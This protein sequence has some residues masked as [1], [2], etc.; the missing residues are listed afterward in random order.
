MMIR[1][2]LFT[3]ALLGL[4]A[5]PS[6]ALP[7]LPENLDPARV[8]EWTLVR[9]A[10]PGLDWS[11]ANSATTVAWTPGSLWRVEL[12]D[13]STR[14]LTEGGARETEAEGQLLL[15]RESRWLEV[16]PTGAIRLV[17]EELRLR[18]LDGVK[19]GLGRAEDALVGQADGDRELL[20]ADHSATVELARAGGF[21]RPV[22]LGQP[23]VFRD[24][25]MVSLSLQPVI[26]HEGRL[27]AVE[28]LRLRLDYG[29]VESSASRPLAGLAEEP[30][31]AGNELGATHAWSSNWERVY[32]ALVPNHGQFYNQVDD[33]VFPVYVIVGSPNY[34]N[35]VNPGMEEFIKWKREKG[36]DVRIVTF[37]QMPGGAATISFDNLRAWTRTMWE[38]MR[39]EFLLLIG[40]V[41]GPAACP[42]SVVQAHTGDWDV[43]DHFY[44]LQEGTDFFPELFVGRYSVDSASQ[45]YVMAQKPVFHE[46]MPTLS[47]GGWLTRGLVVSCN[48]ADSGTPPISPNL[49]SRWV[50]DKLRANG[51]TITA[52][53]S[54]FYPPLTNG[55]T[56]IINAL[57]QG[58]GIV[59]YRGWANSNGWIYPAFDRS[60][61]DLL[62]N[63]LRM[64]VVGSFVCQTGA[65]GQGSGDVIVEDPCFGEKFV[66]LGGPGA[67]K[68]AV[69]FVG[70]S[71]LHTRTQY[72]NPVCSGFFTAIFDLNMTGIG[73]ALLN[74]KMEL[75]NGYPLERDDPYSSYFYFHIYNVLGDPDLNIWRGEPLP[76]VLTAPDQL[77][78][79]QSVLE[80][81]VRDQAGDPV[82]GAVVTLIAGADGSQ[83][84][85]RGVT[86]NGQVLLAVDPAQLPVGLT[87]A[88]TANHIDHLP[89]QH[90]LPVTA[91]AVALELTGLQIVEETA[92]G[93][94][95][96]GEELEVRLTLRASGTSAVPEGTAVLRDPA[97]WEIL[98]DWFTIETG[99]VATPAIPAGASTVTEEA[100][101]IRLAADAPNHGLLHLVADLAAGPYQGVVDGRLTLSNLALGL[102]SAAWRSGEAQ[103]LSDR[104]DTLDLVL[105]NIGAFDLG[106]AQLT[107]GSLDPRIEVEE[108]GAWLPT[109]AQGATASASFVLEGG[110]GLFTGQ[111]LHVLLQVEAEGRSAAL[112]VPLPVGGILPEDP[113][114]PDDHGYYAIESEDYDVSTHPTFDWVELDPFYGGSGATRLL[115][116]DDAVTTI[117]LPFPLTH[118]GRTG[119]RLSICSNGWVSL[120]DTWIDDFR[121]WNLPSSLGPPNLIAAFW[122]DLKPRYPDSLYVPVYWRHDPAEGRVV[123]SWSRTYNRYA[124]ENPGQPVQE[125]QLIL[126]DQETRPTPTG[127]TE[128]LVQWK[129]VT[130]LDQNN[131][132]ATCG[133][134]NYGHNIGIQVSYANMP[135]PGCRGFGSGR[136]VLFTTRPPLHDSSYRVRVLVPLPQQWL[137]N[138]SPVLRWDHESFAQVLQRNDLVYTVSVSTAAELLF[139]REVNAA[140]ELDL[141]G[142]GLTLPEN[143]TLFLDL[144]ARA[145]T[146][147]YPA[148]QGRVTFFIDATAPGLTPALLAS[149]LYPGH[150]E[151]GLLASEPLSQLSARVLDAQGN[152]VTELVQDPG[153][154]LLGSG[155]ELRYL[156]AQLGTGFHLL[157]V[158]ATDL[159]GLDAVEEL[160]LVAAPVTAGA[161]FLPGA[162]EAELAWRGG[163][164]WSLMM[165]RREA[166]DA[167]LH[168]LGNDLCAV[169]LRLPE[170][171]QQAW[172]QLAAPEGLVL[173][174]K[175]GATWRR[176]E[177]E[178]AGGRLSARLDRS[179]TVGLMPADAV[180]DVAPLAFHLEGNHPN[181][182]NP[183][184]WIRFQLPDEGE[185]RLVIYNLAG[186]QVRR[187]AAGRLAA[188]THQVRWDGR[189]DTGRPVASGHYLARLEWQGQARTQR[190]LLIR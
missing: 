172:L 161:L 104:A 38:Q 36:F 55:A 165:G 84:L 68:G 15:P 93:Q 170:G 116:T 162:A 159:H 148:L 102:V 92:D 63:D 67:P 86:R 129:D 133:M 125:F 117:D 32:Q 130:D 71:D 53:D 90:Y 56:P 62:V 48:Y 44:A 74:G 166:G 24:L 16:P 189:S 79:G 114:G 138:T 186:E 59:S 49:T 28:S 61:M 17:V 134:E 171:T 1:R 126:Y 76:M 60:H 7:P 177:Q 105:E 106:G 34:L 51:F 131:N 45:L 118:Y 94:Y 124:W 35:I 122:D 179:M 19:L 69:A 99:T 6:R 29:A 20:D 52:Q 123:V 43:S 184:T 178:R 103:L 77:A 144:S 151:L 73:A 88:L 37:D 95:R 2:P 139:S 141:A 127:D 100:F 89:A 3:L 168:T 145:D 13:G 160:P 14:F 136:G 174:G 72:N 47:G 182:F 113:M 65:F 175:E 97:Q 181:P 155:Q 110:A 157:H 31:V 190:M 183:E 66:R 120:G 111:A 167:R 163:A 154:T 50:I 169:D 39:P 156:R 82:D 152:L 64:P 26:H 146:T 137:T 176:L 10:E 108:G 187:I 143:T 22:L 87:T 8:A 153:R 121:N 33:S 142:Q 128:I 54:L 18:P 78:P 164:G 132:F 23:V 147:D 70:P 40:D 112:P 150:L 5:A 101:R 173:V 91:Q 98:P 83:M 41:D 119:S 80:V 81:L 58:R 9:A 107:L 57:N 185:T 25:R 158:S 27:Q 188:G 180:A 4:F 12:R 42:T 96:A 149:T 75:Y 46:K 140:G 109:L 11:A 135:S 21:D 85:A 30:V 115:L